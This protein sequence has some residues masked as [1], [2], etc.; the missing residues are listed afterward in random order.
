MRRNIAVVIAVVAGCQINAETTHPATSESGAASASS[1]ASAQKAEEEKDKADY[2]KYEADQKKKEKADAEK[3]AKEEAA[4][5]AAYDADMKKKKDEEA[6]KDAAKSKV[7][8]DACA[9]SYPV[10]LAIWTAAHKAMKPDCDKEK[11][12]RAWVDAKCEFK[13][14]TAFKKEGNII[15]PIGKKNELVCPVAGRPAG[16][17]NPDDWWSKHSITQ[18]CYLPRFMHDDDE[19]VWSDG[20]HGGCAKHDPKDLYGPTGTGS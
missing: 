5:L 1:A 19:K 3:Q 17:G 8:A 2:A 6:A 14:T 9:K 4:D 12:I 18:D 15:K 13:D 10:R 11:A 20:L 16:M 7:E